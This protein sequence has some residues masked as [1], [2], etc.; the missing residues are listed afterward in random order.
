MHT[1][2]Y[3]PHDCFVASLLQLLRK[4]GVLLKWFPTKDAAL[5]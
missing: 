5:P 4:I 1:L 3:R 2:A